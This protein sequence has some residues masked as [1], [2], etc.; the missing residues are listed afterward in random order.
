MRL[1]VAVKRVIDYNARVRVK[2]DKSGVDLSSVKMSMN[3]FCEI[4]VEEA[5]RIKEKK[6]AD[7][8]V[9]VSIGPKQSQDT[10]R[11]ALAMG[12]DRA[13]HIPIDQEVSPL[14]IAHLLAA[15]AKKE[16][17]GLIFLGKQAIDNDSNQTGQMLAGLLKWPQATFASQVVVDKSGSVTVTREI[18]QGL[19]TLKLNIPAVVTTDLRLN[20][21]RYATLPNIMKAKKK[22]NGCNRTKG[23]GRYFRAAT[24]NSLCRRACQKE[25]RCHS[26]FCS[27]VSR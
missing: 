17:P 10:L 23:L 14:G 26:F 13:I 16:Q 2:P 27:R 9:A 4:A 12:A 24:T 1:L 11:T 15:I 8:V 25:R 7:E 22:T 6:E 19:E 18:D 3:P 5:L 21:P 20:E